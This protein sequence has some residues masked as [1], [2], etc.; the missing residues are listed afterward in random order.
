MMGLHASRCALHYGRIL[1]ASC[2]ATLRMAISFA[3]LLPPVVASRSIRSLPSP[4]G[5][6]HDHLIHALSVTSKGTSHCPA[7][8]TCD[9][10]STRFVCRRP[11][12]G[13]RRRISSLSRP[14]DRVTWRYSRAAR[15]AFIGLLV[16]RM[17]EGGGERR[18]AAP[19]A[20]G[21][22]RAISSLS[23]MRRGLLYENADFS[24]G[25]S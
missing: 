4:A 9:W 11:L 5:A 21:H 25:S 18:R 12:A 13:R 14:L 7:R 24:T 3:L 10:L 16:S 20:V 17:F 19:G 23:L 2:I 1:F 6:Q 22:Q 8:W 15:R